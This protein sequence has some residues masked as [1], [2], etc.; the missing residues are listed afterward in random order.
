MMDP[1]H[2]DAR[3]LTEFRRQGGSI[4]TTNDLVTFGLGAATNAVTALTL[5]MA[6][7]AYVPNAV[8]AVRKRAGIREK[9]DASSAVRAFLNPSPATTAP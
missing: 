4:T 8:D 5:P 7:K 6:K 3:L 9:F 2:S 1:D